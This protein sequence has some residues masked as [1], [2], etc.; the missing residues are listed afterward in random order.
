M[1]IQEIILVYLPAMVANMAPIIAHRMRILAWLDRPINQRIL[2]VH[3]TVRGFVVGV[4][5]G[6]ITA[7]CMSFFIDTFVY[8]DFATATAFGAVTGLGALVGD[9][10]KS[11]FKRRKN[12][13]SGTSWIP[14]DQIDFV[15]GATLFGLFFIRIPILIVLI[16]LVIVGCASYIV[17]VV[18]VALHIKRSL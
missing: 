12:I 10:V 16:A 17:S 11:F 1:M 6:A 5:A 2:G 18:S 14:Y 7:A 13:S 9:S 8:A 15:L 4:G 3:K